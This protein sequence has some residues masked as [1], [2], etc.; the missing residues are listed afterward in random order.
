MSEALV[1]TFK[2]DYV[3]CNPIPDAATVLSQLDAWF[4][5]YNSVHPHGS[6]RMLSPREFI[7]ANSSLAACP[8]S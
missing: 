3:R 8:A 2:R 7:Y 6:L 1:K 4:E 5:D